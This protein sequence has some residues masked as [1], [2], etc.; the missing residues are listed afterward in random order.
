MTSVHTFQ[1]IGLNFNHCYLAGNVL[2]I[3]LQNIFLFGARLDYMQKI[4]FKSISASFVLYST[5][6]K[7]M[8]FEWRTYLTFSLS[9]QNVPCLTAF[10]LRGEKT[11]YHFP[12]DQKAA[13][14]D[15]FEYKLA[16]REKLQP[17]FPSGSLLQPLRL[18]IQGGFCF[19]LWFYVFAF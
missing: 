12:M 11:L 14:Q 5:P 4:F 10:D 9:T 1:E 17:P 3:L 7:Q 18:S 16:G 2:I 19:M 8:L 15:T 6:E 13:W